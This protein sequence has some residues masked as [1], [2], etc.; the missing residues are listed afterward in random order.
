[1]GFGKYT[2]FTIAVAGGCDVSMPGIVNHTELDDVRW[3]AASATWVVPCNC[4]SWRAGV[5]AFQW[6][7]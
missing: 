1:M 4:T 3:T 5:F 7:L 6:V 2:Q